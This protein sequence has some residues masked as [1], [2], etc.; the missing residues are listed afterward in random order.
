MNKESETKKTGLFMCGKENKKRKM[1]QF[2]TLEHQDSTMERIVKDMVKEKMQE[3]SM[4]QSEI[5]NQ[6]SHVEK[7][8]QF[9]DILVELLNV[10]KRLMKN[11]K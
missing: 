10:T 8:E 7:E 5:I 3:L 11:M 4:I 2:M 6:K 1:E 9:E